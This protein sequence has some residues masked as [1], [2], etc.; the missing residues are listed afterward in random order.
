MNDDKKTTR[1]YDR[2]LRTAHTPEQIT[3]AEDLLKNI[4]TTQELFK[5]TNGPDRFLQNKYPTSTQLLYAQIAKQHEFLARQLASTDAAINQLED[6]ISAVRRLAVGLGARQSGIQHTIQKELEKVK[7]VVR[8][9][10]LFA[11]KEDGIPTTTT[12]ILGPEALFSIPPN[13]SGSKSSSRCRDM[14]RP[15]SAREKEIR[16]GDKC[17]KCQQTDHWATDHCSYTCRTCGQIAPGHATGTRWCPAFASTSK[18]NE[19]DTSEPEYFDANDYEDWFGEDGEH[20]L[21]T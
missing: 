19:E 7:D 15:L 4:T 21:A 1:Q 18:K 5:A 20:N 17:H 11:K 2:T 9:T 16:A 14:V 3:E 13:S 12:I 10:D 8:K 6:S